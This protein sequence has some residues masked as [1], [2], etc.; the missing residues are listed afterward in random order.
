MIF[1]PFEKRGERRSYEHV[2]MVLEDSQ[3]SKVSFEKRTIRPSDDALAKSQ[4]WPINQSI[5][6]GYKFK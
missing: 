6:S 4:K 5:R 3:K 1:W 2:C